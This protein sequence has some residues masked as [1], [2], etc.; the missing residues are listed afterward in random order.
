MTK[1]MV[2]AGCLSSS[3][4]E[5]SL[6]VGLGSGNEA[7]AIHEDRIARIVGF[8]RAMRIIMTPRGI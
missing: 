7:D 6:G 2:T 3:C 1:K 4:L 8:R 5:A